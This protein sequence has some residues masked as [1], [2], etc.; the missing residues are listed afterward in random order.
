MPRYRATRE[1]RMSLAWSRFQ[2]IVPPLLLAA[3]RLSWDQVDRRLV[4]YMTMHVTDTPWRN[5]LAFLVAISTCHA[6]LDV[7][8]VKQRLQV[9]HRGWKTIFSAYTIA[10]FA[11]W[12][13]AEHLRRYMSDP[14]L[15][16]SL[17][18][19]QEFLSTYTASTRSV[20][21]YLRSL[22]EEERVTYR[23]WE[24]PLLPAGM[25][26]QLARHKE[27]Q[28]VQAQRRKAESDA[29]TPHFARIRGQA[30][31]RWNEI[32][33]LRQKFREV[34]ALVQSGQ[35][36]LPVSFSYEESRRRQRLHFMLWNRASFVAAH[37]K[38][39]HPATVAKAQHKREAFRPE[40][41]HFFL[42][43]TGAENLA[44]TNTP[45]D[46]DGLLWFSDLLRYDVLGRNAVFGTPEEVQHKQAYVR[47]WGYGT[48]EEPE[49]EILPFQA[50]H[51][52]LLT[53][54]HTDGT[55]RFLDT[56]QQR[57]D[58]L[59][60]LVEPLFAA[61]TFGLASLDFFTTTGARMTELLQLSLSA[62]CL[63]T[64]EIGG[65]QRLLVRLV[66]KGMDKPAEYMVGTET[67]RNLER[68]GFMLK[69]QYQALESE[70][71]P[72][73][74][75]NPATHREHDFPDPRPYLFQYHGQHLSHKAITACMR[76][77]CHGM[78][79]TSPDGKAVVLKAHL[80]RHVFATHL[81]Q[82]EQ[83]PLDIVAKILHQKDVRVTGYYAAPQ[84]Q[85]A[86]TTTDHLLDSFATHLGTIEDAFVRAPAELQRQWEETKQ[87]V[88]SLARVIGGEC[89]CHAVCPI[90]FACTG[91]AYKIPDPSRRE[92]MVQ[93]RQWAGIRYEQV[94]RQGLGPEA[95][96]MQ[97]LIQRCDT[98]LEEMNLMEEY[99]KDEAYH[100]ELTL[101]P[102]DQR[103][104]KAAPVAAETLRAEASA[105]HH[106]RQGQRRSARQKGKNRDH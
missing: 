43:F 74:S 82:V 42:E 72:H 76:F 19:R 34:V 84:W 45:R 48:E 25:R 52:G 59:L 36:D 40:R 35:A 26:E 61:A 85:Q 99:R 104:E 89:C 15:E 102:G 71:L 98:E 16:D 70:T 67:R 64:M 106:A 49:A 58:G 39:Y 50:N 14:A 83:V 28:E 10:G 11:E 24:L 79:F 51:P 57:T 8:T 47:S 65:A 2:E 23:Q 73:V 95:V 31:V 68:V 78:I 29:V 86:V 5:P 63:Y 103:T 30:H 3:P 88:G 55:A 9:L 44:A 32:N 94:K 7:R 37:A 13:P 77:L 53:G 93:Q 41:D 87:K 81:H 54:G 1:Q 80:L 66:P 38:Q 69:D 90:S 60:V 33:R 105:Y 56:A 18:T 62:D 91:C 92:E 100:P 17:H 101:E 22:P 6:R 21:M 75:F 97:A 96:K 27:V 20:A 46:P 12:D 4:N